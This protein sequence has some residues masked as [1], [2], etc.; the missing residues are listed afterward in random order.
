MINPRDFHAVG[1]GDD[2]RLGILLFD[3]PWQVNL[4]TLLLDSIRTK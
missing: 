2:Q 3:F 4:R 1:V